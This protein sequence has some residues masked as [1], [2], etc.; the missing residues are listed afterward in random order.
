MNKPKKTSAQTTENTEGAE[1][2]KGFANAHWVRIS[3]F[4]TIVF[5]SV[6]PVPSVV[7]FF[8]Q[9][10][11]KVLSGGV[12]TP[13]GNPRKDLTV[14]IDSSL[15]PVGPG[16]LSSSRPKA[17]ASEANAGSAAEVK[18]SAASAQISGASSG[19]PINGARIA[20]IKQAISEGRF[21]VN[22][23]AIA[24]GLINTARDLLQSQRKA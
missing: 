17:A 20:E 7:N 22:A 3:R 6:C 13:L 16:T 15:K 23:E 18:L 9:N 4:P 2:C 19:A 10:N 12:V 8:F 11:A 14:K 5:F 1:K 24:D 21:K